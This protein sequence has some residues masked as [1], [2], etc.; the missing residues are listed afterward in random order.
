M[1]LKTL[2]LAFTL[3]GLTVNAQIYYPTTGSGSGASITTGTENSF[4]GVNSG[5]QTT[6]GSYNS[7]LGYEVGKNNTTGNYNTFL[8]NKTGYTNTTGLH[9]T[10]IGSGSG[11]YSTTANDNTFTGYISGGSNTTGYS[12]SFFGTY[13][14][15]Y[16]TTGYY[17]TFSG[18]WSGQNNTTGN[19]NNFY[20]KQSGN[21]NTTGSDNVF[22]GSTCGY[23]NST[24]SENSFLGNNT[25]HANDTGSK[26]VFVGNYAGYGN[27]SF[28]NTFLG[29]ASGYTNDEGLQ[30]T[31]IG[32]YAGFFNT[33]GTR[34]TYVGYESGF[35]STVGSVGDHIP[36]SFL[37]FRSG[38]QNTTGMA[39]NFFGSQAGYNNSTGDD[40]V[41][42]GTNAGLPN[43]IG[44]HNVFLGNYTGNNGSNSEDYNTFVGHVAGQYFDGSG[45][46]Y[47]GALTES[48]GS[49]NI[50]IGYNAD[51]A[52]GA[53]GTISN[54]V[55]IGSSSNVT[56]SN[57]MSLGGTGTIGGGGSSAL[58]VVINQTASTS[59]FG[60]Q[61][62]GGGT[63]TGP[64]RL[65]INGDAYISNA[66]YASDARYKKDIS[67]IENGLSTLLKLNPVN[68][69]YRDDIFFKKVEGDT[70]KPLKMEFSKGEQIGFLAQELETVVPSAVMTRGDGYKAVNYNQLLGLIVQ[71]IKEQN[72]LISIE[73]SKSKYL[74][75]QVDLLK[76]QNELLLKSLKENRPNENILLQDDRFKIKLDLPII[77]SIN[78]N[79]F[80]SNTI[81]KYYLPNTINHAT[82]KLYNDLGIGQT[83][84]TI[85]HSGNGEIMIDGNN[86]TAGT[87]T[88]VL[89]SNDKILDTE[90]IVLIK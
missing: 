18:A 47:I 53:M 15:L 32:G 30:N 19:S 34:H 4:F 43:T 88:V 90:K 57:T 41:F 55:A 17:N 1:N 78:P 21:S 66:W 10:F 75:E 46:T 20:G 28:A 27:N 83:T 40:N 65:E 69:T 59:S 48:Y 63:S 13:S 68:Y 77:E 79:P 3:T 42:F 11:Y 70:S 50:L 85:E 58:T 74:Q 56:A 36:N 9:N 76:A 60:T 26:N 23:N 24:G 67:P 73:T 86:L 87:Y 14:G 22:I 6:S 71:S 80:S 62:G 37:G 39:N 35:N 84:F 51:G 52:T 5:N 49:N 72:E 44:E 12:N 61:I 82:I 31:F 64:Y 16:N 8:G 45:N 81:I 89:E 29:F 25:G 33:S 54:A 38:Y 2:L 7:F